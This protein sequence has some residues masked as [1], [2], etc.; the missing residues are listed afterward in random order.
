MGIRTRTR[1]DPKI[2]QMKKQKLNLKKSLQTYLAHLSVKARVK[3]RR[4]IQKG[5]K[6]PRVTEK[7]QAPRMSGNTRSPNP[8][9]ETE[10]MISTGKTKR[11]IWIKGKNQSQGNT[12]DQ[13]LHQ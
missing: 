10:I 12:Q 2:R 4:G 7:N 8:S 9:T 3:A 13:G 6:S 11:R 5:K 1:R